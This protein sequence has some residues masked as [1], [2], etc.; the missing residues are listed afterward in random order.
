MSKKIEF[1]PDSPVVNI[2]KLGDISQ[3]F[4]DVGASK[5]QKL[6]LLCC[7]I[8]L[9]RS[10]NLYKCS[11][12]V[13]ALLEGDIKDDSQYKL[14]LRFFN[15]GK[16]EALLQG[17]FQFIIYL[18]WIHGDA[19]LLLDR[20]QWQY[21]KRK[22]VNLLV[23]G[24]VYKGV[25]VPL[26]WE[27]LDKPGK[28]N[29]TERLTLVDKLL[30]WWKKTGLEVPTLYIVGDREFIGYQWL[31]GLELRGIKYVMRLA[32]NRKFM[33]YA[34]YGKGKKAVRLSFINR[35]MQRHKRPFVQVVIKDDLIANVVIKP[36]RGDKTGKRYLYL[37]TNIDDDLKASELYALR[38]KIE[39][40][41][42]HLKSNGFDLEAMALT[43]THKVE[44]MFGVLALVYAL[45]I[46][47]G[48]LHYE[49][50]GKEPPMKTYKNGTRTLKKSV[51]RKGKSILKKKIKNITDFKQ[52]I[53][54][55][56]TSIINKLKSIKSKRIK[57]I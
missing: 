49:Q 44:L 56:M 40:C 19:I 33:L 57:I 41:F 3:F 18:L 4:K 45:A 29:A 54:E 25:F 21:G 35:W 2:L 37:I 8:Y 9:S 12:E 1:N 5:V 13:G 15:T 36:L 30:L 14:L 51:F 24:V 32:A 16:T 23:I 7:C 38:W 52:Y 48:A 34:N 10:A 47:E 39:T 17:I 6:I 50:L 53:M 28:S 22:I 26:V 20:T 43:Q 31:R 42:K 55:L 11:D 27:D 46:R